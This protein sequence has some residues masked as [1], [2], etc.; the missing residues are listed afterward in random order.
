MGI[1]T[2]TNFRVSKL[3]G[4]AGGDTLDFALVGTSLSGITNFTLTIGNATNFENITGR[5]E[6]I[7]GDSN[8]NILNG[9]G[10]EDTL[11]GMVGNDTPRTGGKR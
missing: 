11:Y 8:A 3:D 10:G 1:Q 2:G 7:T 6:T 9:N 5:A 4:G